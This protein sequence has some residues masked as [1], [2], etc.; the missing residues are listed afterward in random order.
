MTRK[1]SPVDEDERDVA[2]LAEE[3]LGA[4]ATE[5]SPTP[6]DVAV[7]V[8]LKFAFRKLAKAGG[9]SRRVGDLWIQPI[10]RLCA[11]IP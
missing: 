5:A 8:R 2:A 3:I 9:H 6:L 11:H 10:D 1:V 4:E 7:H